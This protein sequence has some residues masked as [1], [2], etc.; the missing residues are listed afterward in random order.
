M[1][2]SYQWNSHYATYDQL[3]IGNTRDLVIL[4]W[5]IITIQAH[6]D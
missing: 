1:K 2:S 6:E 4:I 3:V 5:L